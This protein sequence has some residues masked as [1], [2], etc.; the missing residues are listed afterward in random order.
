MKVG[1]CADCNHSKQIR[2]SRGSVFYRCGL[3]DTD[4]RFPKYPRLP[5]IQ[6]P[7]YECSGEERSEDIPLGENKPT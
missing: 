3:S 5:M 2:S 4:S 6:C 1:L 7:G